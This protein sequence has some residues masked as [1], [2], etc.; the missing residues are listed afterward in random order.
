MDSWRGHWLLIALEAT[1]VAAA[2]V[3]GWLLGTP[4][5]ARCAWSPAGWAWGLCATLPMLAGLGICLAW[6]NGPWRNLVRLIDSLLVPVF[7]SWSLGE[8]AVAAVLAGLGE[9][10]IFRGVIQDAIRDWW[11]AD[12]FAAATPVAILATAALFGLAHA[13]TRAYALFA[14]LVG[15]YLGCLYV[16]VGDLT[17]PIVAHGLYDFVALVYLAKIHQPCFPAEKNSQTNAPVSRE[18]I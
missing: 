16:A 8:L 9:E 17:A 4:P 12:R 15:I 11:S 14:T 5:L 2:F 13:V 10:M 6:P 3:L 7:R 1:L 18:D